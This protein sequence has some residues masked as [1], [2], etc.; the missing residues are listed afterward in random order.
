MVLRW[1]RTARVRPYPRWAADWSLWQLKP[2]ATRQ[3]VAENG[4]PR[5]RSSSIS[6]R[7]VSPQ[8]LRNILF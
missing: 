6:Q 7:K 1:V 8:L 3:E 4:T 2:K 5:K